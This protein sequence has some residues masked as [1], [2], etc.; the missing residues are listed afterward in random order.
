MGVEIIPWNVFNGRIRVDWII[1]RKMMGFAT[2]DIKVYIFV[3]EPVF[4][5]IYSLLLKIYLR[6]YS[7]HTRKYKARFFSYG[8]SL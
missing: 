2:L 6:G 4:Y 5:N 1:V 3:P 8:L 7:V